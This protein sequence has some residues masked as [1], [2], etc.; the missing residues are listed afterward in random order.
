[1]L[2]QDIFNKSSKPGRIKSGRCAVCGRDAENLF[3]W[4]AT[5]CEKSYWKIM[6]VNYKNGIPV[7]LIRSSYHDPGV[8]IVLDDFTLKP[9]K[10]KS[11]Y[12]NLDNC[13]SCI[14]KIGRRHKFGKR[15]KAKAVVT[16]KL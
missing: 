4:T 12:I 13:R 2:N 14:D 3:P 8:T 16:S 1:M 10:G 7:K 6:E 9:I 15:E 5:I 11:Y